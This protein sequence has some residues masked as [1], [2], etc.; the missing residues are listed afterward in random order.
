MSIHSPAFTNSNCGT[1]NATSRNASNQ[2]WFCQ[3]ENVE[4]FCAFQLNDGSNRMLPNEQNCHFK[5]FV[6]IYMYIHCMRLNWLFHIFVLLAPAS[7]VFWA[8]P[9]SIPN[10]KWAGRKID[11]SIVVFYHPLVNHWKQNGEDTNLFQCLMRALTKSA[12]RFSSIER[13]LRWRKRCNEWV[14]AI[15]TCQHLWSNA[16]QQLYLS[17]SSFFRVMQKKKKHEKS[18]KKTTKICVCVSVLRFALTLHP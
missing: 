2:N 5:G 18:Q 12:C 6:R 9:I 13:N 1:E 14:L 15:R 3:K 7:I 8:R 16:R 10:A 17:Q 4:N 11:R